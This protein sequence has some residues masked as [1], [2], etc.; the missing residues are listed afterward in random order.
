MELSEC[1]DKPVDLDPFDVCRF[2]SSRT[3]TS[4]SI[5]DRI[6]PTGISIMSSSSSMALRDRARM[7]TS[8]CP[9]TASSGSGKAMAERDRKGHILSSAAVLASDGTL[10]M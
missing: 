3:S 9:L 7:R 5:A 6:R 8:E 2:S 1:E 4:G 10:H